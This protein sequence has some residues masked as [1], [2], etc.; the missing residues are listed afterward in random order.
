MVTRYELMDPYLAFALPSLIGIPLLIFW[1]HRTER[2]FTEA[3]TE[4][5]PL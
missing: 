1:Q 5:N 2:K 3:Q 4:S